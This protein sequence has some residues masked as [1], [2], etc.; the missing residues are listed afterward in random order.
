[1]LTAESVVLPLSIAGQSPSRVAR[2]RLLGKMGLKDRIKHCRPIDSRAVS[3][4]R[5]DR[6]RARL[7]PSIVFADESRPA[8]ST[9]RR[10]GDLQLMLDSGDSFGQTT[11]MVTHEARGAAIADRV[12]F[13]A[14]GKIVQESSDITAADVVQVMEGLDS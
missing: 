14:D 2:A 10:S 6:P 4:R 1:M 9:R 3:G 5:G 7:R 11:V 13:L 12:L 8:T